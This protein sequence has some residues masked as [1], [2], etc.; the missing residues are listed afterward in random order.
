MAN[1]QTSQIILLFRVILNG[2]HS[3]ICSIVKFYFFS[4]Q[5]HLIISLSLIVMMSQQ[6]GD[7]F[8][9][10]IRANTVVQAVVGNGNRGII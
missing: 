3:F 8:A 10:L 1:N 9:A 4:E 6:S 7:S 2:P 5:V